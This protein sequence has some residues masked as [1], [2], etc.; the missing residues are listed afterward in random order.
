MS[1]KDEQLKELALDIRACKRCPLFQSRDTPTVSRGNPNSPLLIVGDYPRS[2][3]H[4]KEESFS[5][6]F[7]KKINKLL[8]A[9]DINPNNVYFTQILKCF[10]GRMSYFPEDT[11]P[12]KCFPFLYK[13]IKIIKPI[14]VVLAGPEALNWGLIRG[15]GE[16]IENFQD[17]VGK[18]YRRRDIYEDTKFAVINHPS[19]L[20]RLKDKQI[21]QKCVEVLQLA[22]AYIV[23]KQNNTLLPSIP[24]DLE[25]KKKKSIYKQIDAFKWKKPII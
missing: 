24:I 4:Q 7:G 2:T 9:A 25:T 11:S 23:A 18:L 5:G 6:L 12:A 19:E 16:T 13:Q 21:E 1:S 17:W 10:L 3:D 8:E 22:K 20:K 15:T 14:V